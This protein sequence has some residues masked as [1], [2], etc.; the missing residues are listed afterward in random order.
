MKTNFYN[1]FKPHIVEYTN[2]T[3]AVRKL[4]VFGWAYYDNQKVKRDDYW[5]TPFSSEDA[6]QWY[7]LDSLDMAQTLLEM[8]QLRKTIKSKQIK[9]IYP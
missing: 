8:S 1:P 7:L 2:G 4:T 3:F 5:W 9:R 6:K